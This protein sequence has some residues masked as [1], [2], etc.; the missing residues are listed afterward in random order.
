MCF[1]VNITK[2]LRAPILGKE[3]MRTAAC[4][5]I[6]DWKIINARKNVYHGQVRMFEECLVE[7]NKMTF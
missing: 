7:H 4:T 1:P 3:H 5:N 2:Y 6:P